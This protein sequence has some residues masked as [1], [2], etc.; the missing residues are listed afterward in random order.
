MQCWEQIYRHI[1]FLWKHG[2]LEYHQNRWC[3]QAPRS[4][5]HLCHLAC[6]PATELDS[7]GAGLPAPVSQTCRAAVSISTR[8]L[9]CL[10]PKR[11]TEILLTSIGQTNL[12]F[13]FKNY[14]EDHYHWKNQT[15][16][17]N[18]IYSDVI[19]LP[20]KRLCWVQD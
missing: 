16:L 8:A 13:I 7:Q 20:T 12:F 4:A 9:Q 15:S 5:G 19:L 11:Q 14:I 10:L 18:Q 17:L 6:L 2:N 1:I 3:K